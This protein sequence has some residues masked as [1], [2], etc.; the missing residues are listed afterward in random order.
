[1]T[2]TTAFDALRIGSR[3]PGGAIAFILACTSES[4]TDATSSSGAR[5]YAVMSDSRIMTLV[6]GVASSRPAS[7]SVLSVAA[8][9]F[10]RAK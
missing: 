1:M 8:A 6:T 7:A 4:L 3:R 10:S 5:S 2:Q 9:R